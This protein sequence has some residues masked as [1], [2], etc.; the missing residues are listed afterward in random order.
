MKNLKNSVAVLQP[1][2]LPYIPYFQLIAK[3]DRVVFL[4]D[5]VMGRRSFNTSNKVVDRNG[6]VIKFG[7]AVKSKS[8]FKTFNETEYIIEVDKT[9]KK[10]HH[11]YA[12]AC[13]YNF[14]KDFLLDMLQIKNPRVSDLNIHAI[15]EI[16]NLL[17]FDTKI[18]RSSELKLED[19]STASN[20]IIS[21]CKIFSSQVYVNP[22]GGTSLYDENYFLENGI[23]L[24]FFH[25]KINVYNQF[26]TKNFVP[27]LSIIDILAH[28]TLQEITNYEIFSTK[29]YLI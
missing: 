2:F 18:Y 14:A 21:I 13:N 12:K 6:N 23:E 7:L 15:S 9:L 4:D 8:I 17:E 26:K 10:F 29:R 22:N 27:N 3:V 11:I 24:E 5:V 25:S 1:Y 16:S 28:N 19:V 20:R